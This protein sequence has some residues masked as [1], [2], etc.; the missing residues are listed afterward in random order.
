MNPK[1]EEE[2][3]KWHSYVTS[4]WLRG[5]RRGKEAKMERDEKLTIF[6][7]RYAHIITLQ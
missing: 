5:G 3:R 1:E 7:L 4:P 2:E 6:S